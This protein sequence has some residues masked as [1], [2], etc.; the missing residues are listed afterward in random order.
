MTF[1]ISALE[2]LLLTYLLIPLDVITHVGVSSSGNLKLIREII[3]CVAWRGKNP[4]T[5]AK[6]IK[7]TSRMILDLRLKYVSH[8]TIKWNLMSGCTG[9]AKKSK[10]DNF[11]NNFVYCQPISIIFG[12]YTL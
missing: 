7:K 4:S 1:Y 12:T 5:I 3:F 2:I 11:L 6:D 9:W 8:S 10:P